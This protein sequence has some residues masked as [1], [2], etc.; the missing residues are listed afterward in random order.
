MPR[1]PLRSLS[2]LVLAAVCSVLIATAQQGQPK[3]Q[4]VYVTKTG[5][6]YHRASCRYLSKGKTAVSLSDAKAKGLTPCSVCKPPQ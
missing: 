6:K 5:K 3:E 2:T 1:L 4:T